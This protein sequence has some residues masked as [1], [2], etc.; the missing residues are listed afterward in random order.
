MFF[1]ILNRRF[2]VR[3]KHHFKKL[4]DQIVVVL[5]RARR[6]SSTIGASGIFVLHAAGSDFTPRSFLIFGTARTFTFLKFP[7]VSTVKSAISD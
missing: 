3:L 1:D 4:G 2:P 5:A 7:A 6:H